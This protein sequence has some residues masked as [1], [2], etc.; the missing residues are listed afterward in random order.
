MGVLRKTSWSPYAVG[1]GIGALETVAMATAHEPL[2]ITSPF[3][4]AARAT[5]DPRGE[6]ASV[7]WEW[8]LVLGVLA[9]S[10]LSRRLSGDEAPRVVP[11]TWERD[12]GSSPAVRIAAA[13]AGG[14]L[15]MFGARMARG[16]TSGHG[17]SGSMQFAASSWL[18]NPVMFASAAA[19]A[20]AL[21]RKRER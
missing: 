21:F 2:G 15:M 17:I 18:F 1:A 6:E 3:E 16:C 19:T 10:A 7:D 8:A 5:V 4:E 9:G 14:A 12:V 11:P 20:K 13:A